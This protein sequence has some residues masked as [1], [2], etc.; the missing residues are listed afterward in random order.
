M[1]RLRVTF[2]RSNDGSARFAPDAGDRSGAL[3]VVRPCRDGTAL[4][5][6]QFDRPDAH[7]AAARLADDPAV[8]DWSVVDERTLYV[9][10]RP[11]ARVLALL[12]LLEAHRLVLD[13]PVRFDATHVT[14]SLLGRAG[15]ISDA[16]DA[17]PDAVRADMHVDGLTEYTAEGGDLRS[18]LTDRQR[19]VLDAAV[20]AGYYDTPRT[21]TVADVAAS[22]DIGESTASEHL[23]KIASRVLPHLANT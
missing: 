12:D 18:R 20:A 6:C 2:D 9:H 8:L 7:A 5:L 13:T 3:R 1:K 23:R 17:I 4:E 21:A 11:G 15:D 16:A 19:D 10:L 14:V 22:L